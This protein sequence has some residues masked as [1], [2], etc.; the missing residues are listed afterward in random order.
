MRHPPFSGYSIGMLKWTV[1]ATVITVIIAIALTRHAN[2]CETQNQESQ[3]TAA[4]QPLADPVLITSTSKNGDADQKDSQ[5]QTSRASSR[6][7]SYFCSVVTPANLPTIYLVL[8][9][10][11]GIVVAIGTL[12]MLESQTEAV[13]NSIEV[14]IN[15]ERARIYIEPNGFHFDTSDKYDPKYEL[16]YKITCSGTTP[17]IIYDTRITA[18][19]G[20]T[21]ERSRPEEWVTQIPLPGNLV[22]GELELRTSLSGKSEHIND[23]LD[24]QI[25]GGQL[26]VNF[27]GYVNY[28]DIFF[29]G[30]GFWRKSF[31]YIWDAK[32]ERFIKCGEPWE[33]AENRR[34]PA[35]N[36]N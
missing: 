2:S 31:R 29:K 1:G 33:N 32:Q 17:A 19:V 11:G 4:A 5:N 14:L 34:T 22:P 27:W 35:K 3:S 20:V 9:G 23:V 7:D 18:E 24:E 25:E 8:I 26:F 21:Q 6:A 10:F 15:K 13:E 16:K 28:R 12:K 36:P 30:D